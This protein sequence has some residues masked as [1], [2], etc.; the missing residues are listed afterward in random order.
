M[1]PDLRC[2][3]QLLPQLTPARKKELFKLCM[4]PV[5]EG[6]LRQHCLKRNETL[7]KRRSPHA[8]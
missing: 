3:V 4:L 6:P 2:I 8:I 5:N 7:K 1:R